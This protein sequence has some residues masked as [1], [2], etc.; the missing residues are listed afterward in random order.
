MLVPRVPARDVLDTFPAVS[1]FL[2]RNLARQPLLTVPNTSARH[3]YEDIKPHTIIMPSSLGLAAVCSHR[4]YDI[5]FP[6]LMT[7]KFIKC[8]F[9]A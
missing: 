8:V 5:S 7:L 3:N 4:S 2:K 1:Q 9:A 6:F